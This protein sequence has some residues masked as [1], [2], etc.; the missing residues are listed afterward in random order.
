MQ[1]GTAKRAELMRDREEPRNNC[2]QGYNANN[3]AARLIQAPYRD[4]KDFLTRLIRP[5]KTTVT[6]CSIPIHQYASAAMAGLF[7]GWA[8]SVLLYS[9]A[10][11]MGALAVSCFT[12][13]L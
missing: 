10:A 3:T 9:V 8:T 12:E 7:H 2:L 1:N 5:P 6:A 11:E 4:T 13:H